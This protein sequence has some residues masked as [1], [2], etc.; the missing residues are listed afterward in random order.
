M[1]AIETEYRGPTNTRESRIIAR[2]QAGRISVPYYHALSVEENHDA[3]L[4]AFVEKWGWYGSW[5][6]GAS[7]SDKGNVYVCLSRERNSAI[8]MPHPQAVS[9]TDVVIVRAP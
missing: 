2:A 7:S 4:R 5:V 9:P 1:Q 3:A 8:R 6:R